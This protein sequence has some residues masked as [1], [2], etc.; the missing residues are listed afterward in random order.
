LIGI[1]L[2]DRYLLGKVFALPI[3]GGQLFV[4][5]R[6]YTASA[7]ARLF[8]CGINQFEQEAL[9]RLVLTATSERLNVVDVVGVMPTTNAPCRRLALGELDDSMAIFGIRAS[10]VIHKVDLHKVLAG[11]AARA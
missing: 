6:S 8:L 4:I 9:G 3:D 5:P 11:E 1:M 2:K 10:R 7:N